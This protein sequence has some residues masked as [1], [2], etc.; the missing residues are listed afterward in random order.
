MTVYLINPSH[1]SFGIGVITPRWL[2]VLASATPDTYGPPTLIDETLEP[3]DTSAI[4]NGRH[5]R[6][7]HPYRQRAAR[8]RDRQRGT[9]SRRLRRLRRHSR[10]PVPGRGA[11]PGR[12]PRR[13]DGRRRA[14]VAGARFATAPRVHRVRS[15]T[16]AAS[17]ARRSCPAA[18]T[19]CRTGRY[20]WASVQTVRGCPKHCSF[21]S[22]WRTDGQRP[23]SR[24]VDRVL[25]EIVDLRRR[26]FRF[27]AL[28]DDNF[29]PVTLE[30]L[31]MA[32]AS[33]G[34]ERSCERAAG[35]SRRA[36][37]ADGR[38]RAVAVR[39]RL[40]HPDHDGG[41]RGSGVPRRDAQGQHQGRAGRCRGSHA[42]GVE[43]HLQELQRERRVAGRTPPEL[44]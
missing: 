31:R 9:R 25:E 29:Y 38:A 23:R 12:R 43:G 17:R 3:F 35:D 37:R 28:A 22:V 30:D 26:G 39:H 7:R 18:G 44:P 14:G 27:I 20:M 11:R 21:C 36:V 24:H 5:R 16:A 15:T 34:S 1:V 2:Y 40:L 33:S 8:L 32:G 13:G 10:H 41:R 19:C 4:V 6:H 42:R